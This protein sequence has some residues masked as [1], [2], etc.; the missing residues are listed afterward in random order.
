ML[1][2]GDILAEVLRE[3]GEQIGEDC[4]PDQNGIVSFSTGSMIV[5]IE[6]RPTDDVAFFHAPVGRLSELPRDVVLA[7]LEWN[8]FAQPM[9]ESWLAFDRETDELILCHAAPKS[10]LGPHRILTILGDLAA[11]AE[12]LH[13]TL[14]R[15][16]RADDGTLQDTGAVFD[17][18]R[19]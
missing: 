4:T 15:P 14:G 5:S 17:F 2:D 10:G 19:V 18:I 16:A 9:P 12:H 1:I 7:A 11:T 6:T 8:L 3:L 13:D